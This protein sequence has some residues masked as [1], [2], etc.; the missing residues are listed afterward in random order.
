MKNQLPDRAMPLRHIGPPSPVTDLPPFVSNVPLARRSARR[1]KMGAPCEAWARIA[2]ARRFDVLL[3]RKRWGRLTWIKTVLMS[4]AYGC[5]SVFVGN[6][7]YNHDA[8][9]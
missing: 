3:R 6:T 7:R 8:M 5:Q 2:A 9:K 1:H 4:G